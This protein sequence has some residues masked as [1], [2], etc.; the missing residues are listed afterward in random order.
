MRRHAKGSLSREVPLQAPQ[1]YHANAS[2]RELQ[3]VLP[4]ANYRPQDCRGKGCASTQMMPRFR[5]FIAATLRPV[6]CLRQLALTTGGEGPAHG[7]VDCPRQRL[8]TLHPEVAV[9]AGGA[10]GGGPPLGAAAVEGTSLFIDIALSDQPELRLPVTFARKVLPGHLKRASTVLLPDLRRCVSVDVGWTGQPL[11]EYHTFSRGWT[12][13]LATAG[14]QRGDILR[15]TYLPA[16]AIYSVRKT[17][18]IAGGAAAAA[19]QQGLASGLSPELAPPPVQ[20]ASQAAGG[21]WA[22][23]PPPPLDPATLLRRQEQ[24]I[25][26]DPRG[27][28]LP[29]AAATNAQCAL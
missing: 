27:V 26:A 25:S 18:D 13:L 10:S 6:E 23:I 1:L 21:S 17:S 22:E 3:A 24:G 15:I 9:Y 7:A 4:G 20:P 8:K 11:R 16:F 29:A 14:F 5:K 28:L 2:N 12:E 19:Q